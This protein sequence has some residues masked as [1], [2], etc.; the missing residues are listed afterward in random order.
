MHSKTLNLGSISQLFPGICGEIPEAK[1]FKNVI[2]KF[3]LK[4]I[5]KPFSVK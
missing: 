2:I 4:T 1:T 5:K 3:N